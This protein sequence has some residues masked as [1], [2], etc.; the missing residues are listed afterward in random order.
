[1]AHKRDN[2]TCKQPA[3]ISEDGLTS[4]QPTHYVK[5]DWNGPHLHASFWARYDG[6]MFFLMLT[7]LSCLTWLWLHYNDYWKRVSLT[8][9]TSTKYMWTK[10]LIGPTSGQN[11]STADSKLAVTQSEMTT[12]KFSHVLIIPEVLGRSRLGRTLYKTQDLDPRIMHR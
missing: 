5:Y 8:V 2:R 7:H 12:Y 6:S 10:I 9:L 4:M 1:M 3:F 11:R